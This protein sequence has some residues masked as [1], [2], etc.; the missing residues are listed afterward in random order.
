[1][2]YI[3]ID[4]HYAEQIEGIRKIA[5]AF[6]PTGAKL[7]VLNKCD[8]L[9]LLAR[10]TAAQLERGQRRTASY[11]ARTQADIAAQMRAKKAVFAAM[12]GGE[13]VDL[14]RSQEF[15]LS[16]MHTAIAQIRHD[17]AKKGLPYILCDEW[18]RP[19]DVRPYKR[20]W[21]E[22]KKEASL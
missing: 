16:Q 19:G 15:H 4:K 8:K 20:Y 1:M 6:L 17:I 5:E 2:N 14:T 12:M 18:V 10:K 7:K 21:L 13:R 3:K 11:D 22:E 9:T